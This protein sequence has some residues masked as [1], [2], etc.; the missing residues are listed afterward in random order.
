MGERTFELERA[1]SR[2]SYALAFLKY[3]DAVKAL[4]EL[5][6]SLPDLEPAREL[7][8]NGRLVGRDYRVESIKMERVLNS[9]R[10][11]DNPTENLEF[12]VG[13]FDVDLR[14]AK[15]NE[16]RLW[17]ALVNAVNDLTC[18]DPEACA[19]WYEGNMSG[20]H[21]LLIADDYSADRI[22]YY[23]D[24]LRKTLCKSAPTPDCLEVNFR[25]SLGKLVDTVPFNI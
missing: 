20:Q 24:E 13:R 21:V 6:G 19:P 18:R 1:M 7:I 23:Q 17:E 25:L 2:Y 8:R 16:S 9:R 22:S 12:A 3:L 15:A 5:Q 14:E 4:L 10:D 11:T